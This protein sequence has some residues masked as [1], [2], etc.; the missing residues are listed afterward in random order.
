M[1][2]ASTN[3]EKTLIAYLEKK[4][5]IIVRKNYKTNT[6]ISSTS[7]K[8]P[9]AYSTF[10]SDGTILATASERVRVLLD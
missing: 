5:G 7:S 1:F 4:N 6:E 3:P 10:S 2:A 8:S 9:P